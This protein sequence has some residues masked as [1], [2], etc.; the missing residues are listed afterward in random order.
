MVFVVVTVANGGGK[1]PMT[2]TIISVAGGEGGNYTV[3]EVSIKSK[4]MLFI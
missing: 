2:G 4:Q 1:L 3:A